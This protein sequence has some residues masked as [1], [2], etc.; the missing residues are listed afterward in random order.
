MFCL[1]LSINQYCLSQSNNVYNYYICSF[2]KWNRCF[3]ILLQVTILFYSFL[4]IW[5]CFF[6]LNNITS[7]IGLDCVTPI[8]VNWKA[9]TNH[10]TLRWNCLLLFSIVFF[11]F[12]FF[13]T[14]SDW[15]QILQ[16]FFFHFIVY[17]LPC[18]PLS[19]LI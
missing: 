6:H 8:L 18:C 2:V 5:I 15:L 12:R 19:L 11:L 9:A 14:N 4:P 1:A 10:S 13:F 17:F 7:M 3:K 16:V